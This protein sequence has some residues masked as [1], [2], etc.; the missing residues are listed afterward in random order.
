MADGVGSERRLRNPSPGRDAAGFM[1]QVDSLRDV[2]GVPKRNRRPENGRAPPTCRH[3]A[4]RRSTVAAP[5]PLSMSDPGRVGVAAALLLITAACASEPR[6]VDVAP[7]ACIASAA[8]ADNSLSGC[9][10]HHSDAGSATNDAGQ[11]G[12]AT[13][14]DAAASSAADASDTAATD[15]AKLHTDSLGAPTR[16]GDSDPP[17]GG[18]TDG[19][20]GAP[21]L[22]VDTSA[23]SPGDTDT[24]MVDTLTDTAAP[25]T[26]SSD[27]ET[28]PEVSSTL[29]STPTPPPDA[30][31]DPIPSADA[32]RSSDTTTDGGRPTPETTT[33][34][35][36]AKADSGG[37]PD[38]QPAPLPSCSDG[39]TNGSESDTDCGGSC[40]PCNRGQVCRT[41]EDCNGAHTDG[42]AEERCVVGPTAAFS[43]ST[44]GIEAPVVVHATS[45]A[46]AGDGSLDRVEYD[47]GDGF[48]DTTAHVY[49]SPGTFTVQQRVVDA[50]GLVS[51]VSHQ[52]VVESASTPLPV[53]LSADDKSPAQG[54]DIGSDR[55]T[56]EL[57]TGETAGV[58]SERPVS[59]GSG[60]YYFEAERLA[61]PL[62]QSYV[63]VVTSTFELGADPGTDGYSL[64]LDVGGSLEFGGATLTGVPTGSDNN[65]RHY[66]FAIDYRGASPIVH[67]I[68][69]EWNVTSVSMA[70]V[71]DP[72][73]I[74]VGGRRIAVG[75]QIHIN[76]GNDVTNFPFFYDPHSILADAGIT[77]ADLVLGFGQSIAPALDT[78]PVVSV[79]GPSVVTLGSP[80][81]L[82]ATATDE[83]DGA[84]SSVVQWADLATTYAER[85]RGVGDEW[86]FVPSEP[87]VHPIEVRVTD[88]AGVSTR[89]LWDV[90]VVGE[91]PDPEPL[92]LVSDIHS[93]RGVELSEN[94]LAARFTAHGKY[95]VRANQ[96]LLDGFQYFEM[97]RLGGID[98]LGGGVVT[99]NGDLDPYRPSNVPPS[100]S[101]NFS[102]SIWRNLI[103]VA[104]YDANA[105]EYYGIAVDYRGRHPQVF[106]ITQSV[107]SGTAV[108][109][110]TMVLDDVTLPVYPMVY[111]NPPVNNEAAYDVEINFGA[112]AFY[113]DPAAVLQQAG[114]DA[115]DLQV[116][117]GAGTSL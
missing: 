106:F 49:A 63:G 6:P 54:V 99:L 82:V 102:A 62:F 86:T 92:R 81:A 56:L 85:E 20:S 43:V 75:P 3:L 13:V 110:H 8:D 103:S 95:G 105:T 30:G 24:T 83:E 88:S 100:C 113:Y 44:S 53:Y 114:Y 4:L 23:A 12:G 34:G 14:H 2:Y 42:C 112:K 37:L 107:E 68:I 61:D 115:G 36:S 98:N 16:N 71:S 96:G 29:G 72:V 17:A 76:T 66:G 22:D 84:L 89:Q 46:L 48:V 40:S 21:E 5:M 97:R 18:S 78:P 77:S 27:T 26:S 45:H 55:L 38:A 94:G 109:A 64:G 90:R 39:L 35:G 15:S 57:S 117:W 111:G 70:L 93:G 104:D 25:T 31:I 108:L 41:K 74:F 80:V 32:A 60:F 33:D 79:Q 51:Q 28:E 101:I 11:G 59:P 65:P 87:G 9:V 19:T 69:D 58:R 116:G 91:R 73:Y 67:V 1:C 10:R 52:V 47:F 50:F 7:D